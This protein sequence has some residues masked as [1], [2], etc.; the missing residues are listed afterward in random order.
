MTE[1]NEYARIIM[2]NAVVFAARY[3]GYSKIK[4]N[5]EYAFSWGFRERLIKR[6]GDHIA[7]LYGIDFSNRNFNLAGYMFI[8]WALMILTVDDSQNDKLSVICELASMMHLYGEEMREIVK[9]IRLI[10]GEEINDPIISRY[11]KAV[12]V[13]ILKE[14]GYSD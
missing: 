8:F 4:D 6:Q 3:S 7:E 11:V 12:F 14:Y 10:Y 9:I 5:G 13:L 1:T 2:S